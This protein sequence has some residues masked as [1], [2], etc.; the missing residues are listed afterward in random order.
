MKALLV[1]DHALFREGMKFMLRHLRPDLEIHQASTVREATAVLERAK[2]V[3]L[4]LLDLQLPGM[5]GLDAL[6]A[7]RSFDESVPIVVLSGAED[8][9][10]VHGAIDG[11]AMGFIQKSVNPDA[12]IEAVE[13]VLAGKVALPDSVLAGAASIADGDASGAPS[14]L[15][16]TLGIT[17]RRAEVLLLLARGMS[18]KGIA[19]ELGISDTTVK[20]HIQ[21]VYEALNVHSRTQAIFKLARQGWR[22]AD[23]V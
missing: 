19:R 16:D 5:R 20:T 23:I 3:D 11:G 10:T 1:D 8:S 15:L 13:A 7:M 18:T 6:R 4:I 14:T 17:G 9:A 12:M 22:L 2:P 21:A